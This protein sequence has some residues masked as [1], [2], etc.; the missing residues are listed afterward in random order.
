MTPNI[1]VTT[2]VG[3]IVARG[4]LRSSGSSQGTPCWGQGVLEVDDGG[5]MMVDLVV[6]ED[7]REKVGPPGPSLFQS[8]WNSLRN[9]SRLTERETGTMEGKS[10]QRTRTLPV[11]DGMRRDVATA[12][13]KQ[14]ELFVLLHVKSRVQLCDL[15]IHNGGNEE[16]T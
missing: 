13:G 1:H 12:T 4:G 10:G 15:R 7:R 8:C 6:S 5:E 2:T 9:K 14:A 11:S 16:K 3:F